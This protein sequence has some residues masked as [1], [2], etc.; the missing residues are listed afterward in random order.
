MS[1]THSR[2]KPSKF[3][4][5]VNVQNEIN[6]SSGTHYVTIITF[7]IMS[8]HVENIIKIECHPKKAKQKSFEKTGYYNVRTYE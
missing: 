3:M 8:I 2:I 6:I 1:N 7:I 4:E 5:N